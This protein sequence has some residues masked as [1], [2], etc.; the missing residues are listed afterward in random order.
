MH[1]RNPDAQRPDESAQT[2]GRDGAAVGGCEGLGERMGRGQAGAEDEHDRLGAEE[3]VGREDVGWVRLG[4]VEE[5]RGHRAREHHVTRV[6]GDAL[7]DAR[8]TGACD[9]AGVLAG[10]ARDAEEVV[11]ATGVVC[12]GVH[13][14]VEAAVEVRAVGGAAHEELGADLGPAQGAREVLQGVAP[15]LA[16]ERDADVHHEG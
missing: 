6:V 7:A 1:T 2:V 15:R 14:L 16:L 4:V 10:Q 13:A 5:R 9:A 8:G 12:R 3:G 11:C